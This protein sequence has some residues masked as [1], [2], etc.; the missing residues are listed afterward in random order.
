MAKNAAV[1]TLDAAP[2]APVRAAAAVDLESAGAL[3][4]PDA[5]PLPPLETVPYSDRIRGRIA[6][7]L[8]WMLAAVILLAFATFWRATPAAA[9]GELQDFLAVLFGPLVA[10]VSAA[11]GYYFGGKA[12]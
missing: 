8:I 2:A 10:L 4:T 7:R 9:P 1:P 5:A 3:R 11:V 12:G 6:E